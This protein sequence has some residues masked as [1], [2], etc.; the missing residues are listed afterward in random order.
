MQ[1]C[2]HAVIVYLDSPTELQLY[3]GII[4]TFMQ[5]PCIWTRLP[6]CNCTYADN[7]EISTLL[8]SYCTALSESQDIFSKKRTTF[9]PRAVI[10]GMCPHSLCPGHFVPRSLFPRSL[11]P[12]SLSPRSICPLVTGFSGYFVP[13]H[14]VRGHIVL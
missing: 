8:Q 7:Y 5:L 9:R 4:F 14:F 2:S 12:R 10:A 11:S 1:L 3:E 6:N 13:G